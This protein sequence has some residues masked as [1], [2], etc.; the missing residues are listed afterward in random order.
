[1]WRHV[2]PQ[3][4]LVSGIRAWGQ[5]LGLSYHMLRPHPHISPETGPDSCL[6]SGGNALLRLSC[7]LLVAW[8]GPQLAP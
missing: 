6:W 8:P 7:W 3:R 5:S 1:M 2:Q 4:W